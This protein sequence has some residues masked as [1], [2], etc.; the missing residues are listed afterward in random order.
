MTEAR[1]YH[2]PIIDK[3]RERITPQLKSLISRRMSLAAKIDDALQARGLTNVEFAYMMGKKPSEISR[4]LSGTHNFTTG[5]L[6]E[7]ERVLN[8]Q[9]FVS[10]PAPTKYEMSDEKEDLKN[11]IV[12]E[13]ETAIEKYLSRSNVVIP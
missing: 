7:I 4:W 3:I 9:L 13:V 11:L 6:W 12:Q 10:S 1:K 8:I 5:T 2:S